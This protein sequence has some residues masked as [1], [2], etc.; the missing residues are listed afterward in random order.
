MCEVGARS[1]CSVSY[2]VYL[3]VVL[4]AY[5][6]LG[7]GH[8]FVWIVG[9]A[10]RGGY[11]QRRRDVGDYVECTVSVQRASRRAHGHIN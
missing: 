10:K 6:M 2:L 8:Q 5:S 4:L 9:V 7:R 11:M 3:S 1:S